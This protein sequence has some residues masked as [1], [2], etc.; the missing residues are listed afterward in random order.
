MRS[1]IST[2]VVRYLHSINTSSFYIQNLKT[3]A[4]F[5]SWAGR[6]ESHLVGNP[7]DRFSRDEAQ[8]TITRKV[9]QL[10]HSLKF[11]RKIGRGGV[12]GG[13]A[14]DAKTGHSSLGTLNCSWGPTYSEYADQPARLRRL[15]WV[16]AGLIRNFVGAAVLKTSRKCLTYEPRREKTCFMPMRTTKVQIS[17]W[18]RAVWS[19]P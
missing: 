4:S 17:L 15:I 9:K 18:I 14:R 1:L 8:V 13:G 10:S 3:L 19:A 5:W 12:G 7:E 11:F 2:F 16:F 6:V